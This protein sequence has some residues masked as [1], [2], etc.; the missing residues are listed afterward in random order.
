MIHCCDFCVPLTT[1]VVHRVYA[2][3][4]YYFCKNHEKL[5]PLGIIQEFRLDTLNQGEATP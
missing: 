4:D 5:G 2:K 1:P 3:S